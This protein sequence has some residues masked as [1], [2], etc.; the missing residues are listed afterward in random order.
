MPPIDTWEAP[1]S[2]KH[3]VP[4]LVLAAGAITA[5]YAMRHPAA[6]EALLAAE[7]EIPR[8]VIVA[9]REHAADQRH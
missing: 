6:E 7:G 4:I 9:K 2:A 8:I 3:L 1:M 5:V